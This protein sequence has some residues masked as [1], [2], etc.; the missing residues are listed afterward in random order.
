MARI[1]SLLLIVNVLAVI[2]SCQATS[3]GWVSYETEKG[4]YKVRLPAEPTLSK[5][6]VN[7]P[8]GD[9]QE[10]FLA[11]VNE[12]ATRFVVGYYDKPI[13]KRFSLKK[14]V[15]GIVKRLD[16]SL[17]FDDE[18]RSNGISLRNF[19]IEAAPKG[20]NILLQGRF[21]ITESRIYLLQMIIPKA[22]RG[23]GSESKASIFFESFSVISTR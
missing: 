7:D 19:N 1:V 13:D 10:Q 12:G 18:R 21:V 16:G 20:L 6:T 8:D 14:A 23:P 2:V 5:Q 22:D 11:A 3:D 17:L 4:R 15:E 9:P